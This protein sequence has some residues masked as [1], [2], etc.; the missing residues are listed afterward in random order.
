MYMYIATQ[1]PDVWHVPAYTKC[2]V[3]LIK[4]LPKIDE[5]NQKQVEH[6]MKNKV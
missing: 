1:Q 2:D 6:L 3:Q 4:L 5:Y